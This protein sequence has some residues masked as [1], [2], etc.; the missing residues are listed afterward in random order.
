MLTSRENWPNGI[1]PGITVQ[2]RMWHLFTRRGSEMQSRSLERG[3]VN[4]RRKVVFEAGYI[5]VRYVSH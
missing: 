5:Q 2:V 3:G 4:G 1:G